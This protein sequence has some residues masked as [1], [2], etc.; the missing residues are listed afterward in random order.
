MTTQT[1]SITKATVEHCQATAWNKTGNRTWEAEWFTDQESGEGHDFGHRVISLRA[2][3]YDGH[4]QVTAGI[5]TAIDH[6]GFKV[7]QFRIFKDPLVT[8]TKQRA[9]FSQKTLKEMFDGYYDHFDAEAFY[10]AHEVDH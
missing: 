2:S 3:H 9:R 4:Y 10:A 5:A 8:F 7:R 1:I 6:E